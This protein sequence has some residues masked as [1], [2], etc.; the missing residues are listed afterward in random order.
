MEVQHDF[1]YLK[2][3]NVRK[4]QYSKLF[5]AS[6]NKV[7]SEDD[8]ELCFFNVFATEGNG[9]H[10]EETNKRNKHFR[11]AVENQIS[12]WYQE[13]LPEKVKIMVKS[14]HYLGEEDYNFT[15]FGVS[16]IKDQEI[17]IKVLSEKTR[18]I[19]F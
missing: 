19:L 16:S 1:N 7:M 8:K 11:V 10:W 9:I 5:S 12:P 15:L 6:T 2:M 4:I 14:E 18:Q 3:R 17:V 13:V